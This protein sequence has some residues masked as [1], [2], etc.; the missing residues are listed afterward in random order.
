MFLSFAVL[1]VFVLN[2]SVSCELV[3][4]L[5]HSVTLL[6]HRFNS[7]A[8]LLFVSLSLFC[9]FCFVVASLI[10]LFSLCF[11]VCAQLKRFV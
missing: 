2:W 11:R 7:L 3:A 9:A 1:F 10:F 4:A 6:K 5:T 8:A